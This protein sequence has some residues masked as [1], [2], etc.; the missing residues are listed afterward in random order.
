[1][2]EEKKTDGSAEAPKAPD[3]G[4]PKPAEQPA[5]TGAAPA[6]ALSKTPEEL[7]EEAKA[8][9]QEA[10]S[11][12]T[13][14]EK[15]MEKGMSPIKKFLRHVNIYFLGFILLLV[16]AGIAAVVYYFNS[17][18]VTPP[19]SLATQT[20]SQDALKQLA[21]TDTSVGNSNQTLTIK[22]N[23]IINGQT[24]TRGNLN[25]A[26]NLQTGGSITAPNLTVS[27]TSNLGTAQ[28][29]SLQVAGNVVVQGDTTLHNVSVTGAAA[30]NGAVTASQLTVTHLILSGNAVL[31]VPNHIAFTGPSPVHSTGNA[32]GQ[33]GTT[34]LNG[35]DTT[36][37]A[38]INTG[39]NTSAGCFITITFN[40]PYTSQPHVIVSPV[41][42][43]AGQTQYYVNR[44]TTSFSIC[45]ANAAPANAT[46]AYDY[47]VTD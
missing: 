34:S 41:G 21:N 16:I 36:G 12:E 25:V 11:P 5:S 38:N 20:L 27:G 4:A 7:A 19:A 18:K 2:D 15:A 23:T 45:T 24:L 3:D 39:N 35:S 46:F 6:D 17:R 37:T 14:A 43:A 47:F 1:M 30:F 10:I 26:A 44:S 40:K 31:E 28:I 13:E 9:G 8:N 33:G 42:S 22:G 32:L 29:N